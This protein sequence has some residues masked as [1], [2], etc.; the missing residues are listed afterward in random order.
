MYQLHGVLLAL[1]YQP[2][3]IGFMFLKNI[4]PFKFVTLDSELHFCS[5]DFFRLAALAGYA[6]RS[7]NAAMYLT[8]ACNSLS[9]LFLCLSC[10]HIL[11]FVRQVRLFHKSLSL[12]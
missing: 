10:S 11:P 6:L 4:A 2:V 9:L 12:Q 8:Y 1:S 7:R 3:N 5:F